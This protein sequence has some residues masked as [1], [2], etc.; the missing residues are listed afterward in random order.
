VIVNRV[1]AEIMGRGIVDPV[2]DL[3]ATNPPS[4]GPWLDSL[5]DDFRRHGYDL[6]HLIGTILS[7]SVYALGSEPNDRNVADT[8]NFSR[9][10][11]QR[12]RAEVLLDAI[13]DVTGV[14][15]TFAAAPPGSRAAAIWTHRVPSLFLDTFGR[16]DPNQ[17]PPCERTGDTSVVQAL[18][19]MNAPELH[20]K[21][22]SDA[23]RAARLAAGPQPPRAIVEELYLLAYARRPTDEELAVGVS[24]FEGPNADRRAAVEDLMWALVNSA[25]FVFKD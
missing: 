14:P 11:R 25:E 1:W 10:Y 17:D 23:G 5:A 6:K 9:H 16:P 12:L 7:S 13:S 19:L 24:L 2:D 3:R 8:R 15:D 21:V 22:T 18:H 20:R 4:N